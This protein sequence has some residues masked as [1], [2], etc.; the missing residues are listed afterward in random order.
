METPAHDGQSPSSTDVSVTFHTSM[1]GKQPS[2]TFSANSEHVTGAGTTKI[3]DVC[4]LKPGNLASNRRSDLAGR[5][6]SLAAFYRSQSLTD[7]SDCE[8]DRHTTDHDDVTCSPPLLSSSRFLSGCDVNVQVANGVLNE[9]QHNNND[10]LDQPAAKIQQKDPVTS[11]LCRNSSPSLPDDSARA[12]ST[13]TTRNS[14]RN[15]IVRSPQVSTSSASTFRT[16]AP[17]SVDKGAISALD[18]RIEKLRSRRASKAKEIKHWLDYQQ[19][20]SPRTTANLAAESLKDITNVALRVNSLDA[21]RSLENSP[22]LDVSQSDTS[23]GASGSHVSGVKWSCNMSAILKRKQELDD[24]IRSIEHESTADTINTTADSLQLSEKQETNASSDRKVSDLTVRLRTFSDPE[25]PVPVATASNRSLP[26]VNF[27]HSR[28]PVA[29]PVSADENG[30]ADSPRAVENTGEDPAAFECCASTGMASLNYDR[31]LS[32]ELRTAL[33][34]APVRGKPPVAPKR[35]HV[36]NLRDVAE[37]HF[38]PTSGG[39]RRDRSKSPNDRLFHQLRHHTHV[40]SSS[41]HGDAADGKTPNGGKA[42][43]N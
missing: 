32:P 31:I 41:Y 20:Y 15:K 16:P 9:S 19:K 27:V 8:M 11:P 37:D 34:R 14:S 25:S 7:N 5:L 17:P 3:G 30:A 18:S 40:T 22:R 28:A 38:P 2:S 4:S 24:E 10:K 35:S 23:T 39:Q 33:A 12:S 42:V 13:T 43:I 26:V 1:A 36:I 21:S 6:S 29:K